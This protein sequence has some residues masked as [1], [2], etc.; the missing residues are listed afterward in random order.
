MNQHTTRLT[1]AAALGFAVLAFSTVTIGTANA[2]RPVLA[3][4]SMFVPSASADV[5][6]TQLVTTAQADNVR[7]ELGDLGG[8]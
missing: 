8:K 6:V 4:P 1:R 3:A 5:A 2:S 7:A